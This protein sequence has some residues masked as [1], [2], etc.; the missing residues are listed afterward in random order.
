MCFKRFSVTNHCRITALVVG[1]CFGLIFFFVPETFWDRTPIPHQHHFTQAALAS[2]SSVLHRSVSHDYPTHDKDGPSSSTHHPHGSDG[3][4]DIRKLA[5][6]N[7]TAEKGQAQGGTIAQR[8][9]QR[10]NRVGFTDQFPAE[11]NISIHSRDQ[12]NPIFHGGEPTRSPLGTPGST[13]EYRPARLEV[14]KIE[15]ASS[16]L[17]RPLAYHS[18]S[19][20]VEPRGGAPKTPGLHNLNSPYYLSKDSPKSDSFANEHNLEDTKASI[21]DAGS[22]TAQPGTAGL[23]EK[24]PAPPPE[25]AIEE[26]PATM[27]YTH[28]LRT[29]PPKTFVQNLRPWNGRLRDDKWLKVAV[30]PFILFAYPSILWS[31]LVYSLSI[32]WL[33]VLSESVS[34]IYRNRSSYNFSALGVG[35]VYISPFIGGILGSAVAGK[36]SD[37]VVRFM[38]RRNG[39]VYEPEF[40]LIMAIPITI[41]SV[42]GLMGFGWSAQEKDLWI[43]PTVFFGIISFGCA[44]GSTVSIS[45]AVDS[46]RQYAGEALVTLNFSKSELLLSLSLV[47]RLRLLR[48]H[49]SIYLDEL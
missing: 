42:I 45:F 21:G 18:D 13:F 44:L 43:V 24:S 33:I 2:L 14:P 4:D 8:R 49:D 35:L 34:E 7:A 5:L 26:L 38:S 6:E 30:R 37:I 48:L 20:R 46:Y 27:R 17:P 15:G 16:N 28:E 25:V 36:V 12:P 9:K 31:A 47:R 19:W 3:P 41:S 40:R 1:F 32:G 39:G 10:P 23:S 29:Q 22:M 11:D